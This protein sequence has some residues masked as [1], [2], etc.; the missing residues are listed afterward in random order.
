MN[1]R[2]HR[3]GNVAWEDGI[4]YDGVNNKLPVVV[5]RSTV[6]GDCHHVRAMLNRFSATVIDT[7]GTECRAVGD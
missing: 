7:R 3:T 6:H 5:K 2:R 1:E 4:I